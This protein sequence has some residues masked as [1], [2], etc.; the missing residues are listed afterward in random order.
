MNPTTTTAATTWPARGR[1][2][3]GGLCLGRGPD[4]DRCRRVRRS[5]APPARRGRRAYGTAHYRGEPATPGTRFSGDALS[6]PARAELTELGERPGLACRTNPRASRWLLSLARTRA[7]GSELCLPRT[8]AGRRGLA[9]L[10]CA[11]RRERATATSSWRTFFD[12]VHAR[13][14]GRLEAGG[15]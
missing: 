9:V 12:F 4:P 11:R 3:A 8:G 6:W 13:A 10:I 15:I 14:R 5:T 2:V 7:P 1:D